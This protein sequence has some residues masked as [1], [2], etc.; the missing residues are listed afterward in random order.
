MTATDN[1]TAEATAEQ[2]QEQ[3]APVAEATEAPAAEEQADGKKPA[4]GP[5][6]YRLHKV[7]DTLHKDQKKE[8]PAFNVGDQVKVHYRIVEG[9]KERIQVYEGNV[10]SIRGEGF[11]R[12]F[13]VRRISHDVGVERIFPYH[14]PAIAKVEISRRGRVRRAKLYYLREKS[15]KQGRIKEA[16]R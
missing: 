5:A 2:D 15:G 6:D 10:I 14:S 13:I 12:S 11:H 9:E 7:L 8:W 4:A 16:R 1:E 3:E